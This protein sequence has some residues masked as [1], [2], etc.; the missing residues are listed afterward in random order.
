[1]LNM[2]SPVV[3]AMLNNTPNGI[4]NM[5]VYYGNQPTMTSEVVQQPRAMYPSPKEML[6]N[7]YT[8]SPSP[9]PYVGARSSLFNGYSNPYMGYGTYMGNPYQYVPTPTDKY[10]RDYIEAARFN[11]I[12]YEDQVKAQSDLNKRLS[13]MCSKFFGRDEEE[14]EKRVHIYD[15][16]NRYE[17]EKYEHPL[18]KPMTVYIKNGDDIK[19]KSDAEVP[20]KERRER[21]D[22]YASNASSAVFFEQKQTLQN[23]LYQQAG[24]SCFAKAPDRAY[25]NSTLYEFMNGGGAT[26]LVY[27]YWDRMLEQ[28]KRV[29]NVGGVYN[30]DLFRQQLLRSMKEREGK[31]GMMPDG[32][33]VSPYNNPAV[34]ESFKYNPSTGEYTV[35]A[36]NFISNRLEQAREAFKRSIDETQ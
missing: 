11:G 19:T 9:S 22:Q 33:P 27:D 7:G 20:E 26:R 14:T 5:P 3:Q 35:T 32:R 2:N 18:P 29:G 34:A 10:T 28:Q 1:M 21:R 30:R 15:V 4:G 6:M 31:L 13:R 25:D 23:Q 16:K 17:T 8:F 24:F 36:P 12:S